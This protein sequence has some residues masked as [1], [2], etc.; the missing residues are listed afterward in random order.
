MEFRMDRI[1]ESL[2]S[3]ME[4]MGNTLKI[5]VVSLILGTTLA[6]IIALVRFI[7]YRC[8]P[9]FLPFLSRY[10]EEFPLC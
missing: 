9:R 7:K 1:I 4:Y 10:I 6:L 3:G 2:Q 8:Y 5:S